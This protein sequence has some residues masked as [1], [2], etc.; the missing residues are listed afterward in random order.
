[1]GQEATCTARVGGQVAAGKA[2]LETDELVFRGDGLGCG[3]RSRR[4]SLLR[5]RTVT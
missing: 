3:F 1:M 2:L 4:C 5:L